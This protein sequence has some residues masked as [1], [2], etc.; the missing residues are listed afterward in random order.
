M[1]VYFPSIHRQRHVFRIAFPAV[2]E[3][4]A[5]TIEP[6]SD[7]VILRF[8][9]SG[10]IVNLQWDLDGLATAATTDG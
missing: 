2:D 1:R 9:G 7:H 5:A 8:A 3:E 10:G 6:G 4:G